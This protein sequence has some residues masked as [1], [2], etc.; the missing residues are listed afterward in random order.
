VT[1]HSLSIGN[2]RRVITDQSILSLSWYLSSGFR[3]QSDT[4]TKVVFL[5][6]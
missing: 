2:P 1:V 4:G 3:K 5:M 6:L